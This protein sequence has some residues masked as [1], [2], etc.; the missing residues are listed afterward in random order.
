MRPVSISTFIRVVYCDDDTPPS[1]ATI[2]RRCPHIPGS[3]K[4][5]RRWRIDL[6]LYLEIM[7]RRVRGMPESSQELGFLQ[8]LATQ[9]Q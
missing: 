1:V 2:R 7:N 9:L 4:D 8:T 5:G 3:F 6:D